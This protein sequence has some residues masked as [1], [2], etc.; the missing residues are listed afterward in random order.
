GSLRDFQTESLVGG[1]RVTIGTATATTD[2][3]GLYLLRVPAGF[4]QRVSV[5]EQWIPFVN[6]THPIYRG[7]FYVHTAGC[8]ARYGTVTAADVLLRRPVYGARLSVEG[9]GAGTGTAMT[10]ETGWF[11][12]SYGCPG[13]LCLGSNTTFLS[14]TH[15]DYRAGSFSTGRGICSVDRVDY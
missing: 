15:P 13:V 10:D 11:R 2:A 5:D 3:K 9:P 6:L 12:L 7:D 1:A 8:I 14:V 4:Q